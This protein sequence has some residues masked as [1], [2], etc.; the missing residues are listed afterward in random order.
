MSGARPGTRAIAST[1]LLLLALVAC[2]LFRPIARFGTHTLGA[3]DTISQS[4]TLTRVATSE[5]ISNTD[6]SDP[7]LQF[8]PWTDFAVRELREGRAPLWNPYNGCGIPLLANYQ[9]GVLSPFHVPYHLFPP[10]AAALLAAVLELWVAALGMFAFLSVL[11]RSRGASVF[12]AVVFAFA[13]FQL[14]FLQH[15]HGGTLAFAPLALAC[16][17]RAFRALATGE[18]TLRWLALAALAL[19]L[20]ALAGHPETLAAV[21][22]LVAAWCVA[23][24]L[25]LRGAVA[26]ARLAGFTAALSACALTALMI[27]A[28]QLAPFL[29]YVAHGADTVSLARGQHLFISDLAFQV[30]P[31]LA[32]SPRHGDLLDPITPAPSYQDSAA[33]F[34]GPVALL[35]AALAV[36]AGAVRRR[37]RFWIGVVL[38]HALLVLDVPWL[39]AAL[40]GLLL[41]DLLPA[42]R[43]HPWGLIAISAL[44]AAALDARRTGQDPPLR[45]QSVVLGAALLLAAG[46]VAWRVLGLREA[47]GASIAEIADRSAFSAGSIALGVALAVTGWIV[48]ER[49]PLVGTALVVAGQLLGPAC[50]LGDHVPTVRDEYRLPETPAIARLRERVG[51]ERMLFLTADDVRPNVNLAYGLRT[52]MSYDALEIGRLSRLRERAFGVQ[53]YRGAALKASE[54]ALQLFGVRYIATRGAWVPVGTE[55][56]SDARSDTQL[57]PYLRAEYLGR[58]APEG[59]W[60]ALGVAGLQ[61]RFAVSSDG[62]D[63]VVVRLALP[64]GAGELELEA[65]LGEVGGAELFTRRVR[66]GELPLLAR[67]EAEWVLH[68]EPQSSSSQRVYELSLERGAAGTQVALVRYADPK[69]R[70]RGA[71]D[72]DGPEVARPEEWRL[73]SGETALKGRVISDLACST[74][75]RPVDELGTQTVS[76]FTRSRGRAWLVGT[77]S[78]VDGA[79]ASFERVWSPEFDP[80][81]EVVLERD[82]LLPLGS[83]NDA[84]S[85]TLE[86]LEETP[87]SSRWRARAS[88]AGYAVFAQAYYPGWSARAADSPA[89]LLCANHAFCAVPVPAGD[90]VVELRYEPASVR[91]G[92]VLSVLGLA[93]VCTALLASALRA[94]YLN[95]PASRYSK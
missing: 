66:A 86:L 4:S 94:R 87:T 57:E 81:R 19:G 55:L 41:F 79:Q 51:D 71:G 74:P 30:L 76:E 77:A 6:L 88:R 37:E 16:L 80:Y 25:Q 20:A 54:R 73:R 62:L 5:R 48:L 83:P 26:G 43:L 58:P 7:G 72:D 36:A 17:E 68:F 46:L 85:G 33:Y 15:P 89:P 47:L 22:V 9:S 35:A 92:A 59:R 91:M 44:G 65:T 27:S 14:T 61:Q 50:V 28:L 13:G 49:R 31:D 10:G 63:G 1:A 23:R 60:Q 84:F 75:L 64:A 2:V 93:A 18:P 95:R 78:V 34:V 82:P 29:E 69:A 39:S 67:G 21:G 12:G 24:A 3:W 38:L 90:H 11:G 53:G 8:G 70:A 40:R 56:A 32:G 52:P 42:L 45:A